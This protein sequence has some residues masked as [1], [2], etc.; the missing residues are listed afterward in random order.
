[1]NDRSDRA[2]KTAGSNFILEKRLHFAANVL[3]F[4]FSVILF[5]LGVVC[6]TFGGTIYDKVVYFFGSIILCAVLAVGVR[7]TDLGGLLQKAL[8]P[9]NRRDLMQVFCFAAVTT[10]TLYYYDS[11]SEVHHQFASCLMDAFFGIAILAMFERREWNKTWHRMV[12]AILVLCV[13]GYIIWYNGT[14]MG[15]IHR[16]LRLWRAYI[17]LQIAFCIL[18]RIKERRFLKHVS[19]FGMIVAICMIGMV[20]F[21]NT[22]TWPISV[23][24]P[25]LC[26]YFFAYEKGGQNR[27]VRNYAYGL[28]L[29]F[30]MMF[31]TALLFRPYYSFEF[32]RY[33]GWFASCASAGLYWT[34]V[35]AAAF[36]AVLSKYKK[37]GAMLRDYF[38]ELF[39]FA[40]A[41][42]HVLLAMARTTFLAIAVFGVFAFI[43]ME[44]VHYRDSVRGVIRKILLF[45][46][47]VIVLLPT[48]YMLIRC[49]P[50]LVARPFWVSKPEW[51]SDRIM[52]G[53]DPAS[54]KYMN[55][56]QLAESFLEKIVGIEINLSWMAGA[57]SGPGNVTI[58]ENGNE[59]MQENVVATYEHD[60]Q[61]Y[62]LK[63]YTFQNDSDDET[64]NGRFAIFKI[65]F[66]RLNL[67]GHDTMVPEDRDQSILIYHAHNS[68]M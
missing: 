5:T 53:E 2:V 7:F 15:D 64:S 4:G 31:G 62:A 12:S 23:A 28:I 56:P 13:I 18:G 20:V 1:M 50:A 42:V 65:Y 24:V 67:T 68:F 60:G 26:L 63:D 45:V 9:V 38:W 22:R 29:S 41:A 47:P 58:D 11:A 35:L 37:S 30:W 51:F 55:V 44:V 19:V 32:V 59:V 16:T 46:V 52:P 25:F 40:F 54:R 66:D 49:V 3:I 34:V 8:D 57:D 33:P 10:L 36:A 21:R 27:V 61:T 6:N 39:T 17:Y 43:L 48:V 14:A